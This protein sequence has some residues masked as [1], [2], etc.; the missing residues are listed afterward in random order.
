MRAVAVQTLYDRYGADLYARAAADPALGAAI[1]EYAEAMRAMMEEAEPGERP[2][3]PLDWQAYLM[4]HTH[5]LLIRL[6][7]DAVE[8]GLTERPGAVDGRE[9]LAELGALFQLGF[10]H[11]LIRIAALDQP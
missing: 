4:R 9:V 5:A 6:L 8:A 1:A 11:G 3:G 10:D 2:A 7:D